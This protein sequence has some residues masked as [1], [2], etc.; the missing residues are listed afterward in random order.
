MSPESCLNELDKLI[1]G[2][3]RNQLA[4]RYTSYPMVAC[5]KILSDFKQAN[6]QRCGCIGIEEPETTVPELVEACKAT[7]KYFAACGIAW[8]SNDGILATANGRPVVEAE[9]LDQLCDA[10]CAAVIAALAKTGKVNDPPE[11]QRP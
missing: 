7:A 9:G 6:T 11:P 1:T 5:L 3:M 2:R 8:Q 10:A 4:G